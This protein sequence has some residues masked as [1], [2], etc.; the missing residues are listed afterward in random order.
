MY[1]EFNVLVVYREF[2]GEYKKQQFRFFAKSQQHAE[3]IA[4]E[5]LLLTDG[6]PTQDLQFIVKYVTPRID[7]IERLKPTIATQYFEVV[8]LFE[9]KLYADYL[10]IFQEKKGYGAK[11]SVG[12]SIKEYYMDYKDITVKI[13]YKDSKCVVDESYIVVRDKEKTYLFTDTMSKAIVCKT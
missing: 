2:T 10:R 5:L 3:K 13:L 7:V 4:R 12:S 1:F 11:F 8:K 6:K 9:D